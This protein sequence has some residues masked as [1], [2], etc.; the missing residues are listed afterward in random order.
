MS[1]EVAVDHPISSIVMIRAIIA[2]LPPFIL[3]AK[4]QTKEAFPPSPRT[5]I[6]GFRVILSLSESSL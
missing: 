4:N 6:Q 2:G 5:K 1:A 3:V